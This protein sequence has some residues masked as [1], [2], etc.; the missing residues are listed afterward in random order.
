MVGSGTAHL[1]QTVFTNAL[2]LVGMIS[3][4]VVLFVFIVKVLFVH[5]FSFIFT[6]LLIADV[7][8]KGEDDEQSDQSGPPVDDKH[9]NAAQDRPR[10]R[11]PHVVVLEAWAPPCGDR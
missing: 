8:I 2:F 6:R 4:L 3:A 10:K 11:H 1:L 7:N 9:D 5:S